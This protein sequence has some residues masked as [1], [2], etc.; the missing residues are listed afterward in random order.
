MTRVK[1][2]IHGYC[3]YLIPRDRH[4]IFNE[5]QH[6]YHIFRNN[7]NAYTRTISWFT[8][9][10]IPTQS[11]SHSFRPHTPVFP[12]DLF[13]AFLDPANSATGDVPTFHPRTAEEHSLHNVWRQSQTAHTISSAVPLYGHQE[14]SYVSNGYRGHQWIP[15][16]Q[17]D[18]VGANKFLG[19]RDCCTRK[20]TAYRN[21]D[22]PPAKRQ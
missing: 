18:G 14:I 19:R 2:L 10:K 7:Q 3:S 8:S 12:P 22:A 11:A 15:Q 9:T 16:V 4:T 1:K 20:L 21:F 17:M 13:P 6:I 5:N